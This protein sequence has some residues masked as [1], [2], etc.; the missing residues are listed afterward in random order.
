MHRAVGTTLPRYVEKV[1]PPA[2]VK[3]GLVDGHTLHMAGSAAVLDD[4][5][6]GGLGMICRR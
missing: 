5:A 1:W 6:V 2:W 4:F 3:A